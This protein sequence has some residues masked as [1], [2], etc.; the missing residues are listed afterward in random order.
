MVTGQSRDEYPEKKYPFFCKGGLNIFSMSAVHELAIDCPRHCIGHSYD[1]I[2]QF[3]NKTCLFWIDDVFLGSCVSFTQRDKTKAI[4]LKHKWG[5]CLQ[6]LNMTESRNAS[7]D[8]VAHGI[9]YKTPSGMMQVHKY[10]NDRK[11]VY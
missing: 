8:L 6:K 10:Y 9:Q 2:Q 4:A 1:N 5:V 3:K 7:N 11:L